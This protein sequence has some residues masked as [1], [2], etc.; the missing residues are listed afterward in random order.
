MSEQ[1][2][3]QKYQQAIL[4]HREAERTVSIADGQNAFI[5]DILKLQKKVD[6]KLEA[7]KAA[8]KEYMECD[9]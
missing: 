8:F 9:E 4:E 3:Y 1:D 7:R 6:E 2:K 5:T